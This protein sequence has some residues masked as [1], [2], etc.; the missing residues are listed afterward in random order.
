MYAA[1]LVLCLLCGAYWSACSTEKCACFLPSQ[2][3]VTNGKAVL[4]DAWCRG[5]AWYSPFHIPQSH[6]STASIASHNHTHTQ[7]M[8]SRLWSLDSSRR[9]VRSRGRQ[10]HGAWPNREWMI[11]K[12][13]D[14][15]VHAGRR[16]CCGLG[17]P[18]RNRELVNNVLG[19]SRL[20]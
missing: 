8:V 5:S 6:T 20:S 2:L 15:Y 3:H 17:R 16:A 18:A 19:S 10:Q 1:L 7:A 13:Y 9:C 12:S 11:G 14:A 4:L